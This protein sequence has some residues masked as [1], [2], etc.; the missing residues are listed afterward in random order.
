[1]DSQPNQDYSMEFLGLSIRQI[2]SSTDWAKTRSSQ[3]PTHENMNL[4]VSNQT[5]IY[6]LQQWSQPFQASKPDPDLPSEPPPRFGGVFMPTVFLSRDRELDETLE[7]Q[8]RLTLILVGVGLGI[9]VLTTAAVY[10]GYRLLQT[11]RPAFCLRLRRS[12]PIANTAETAEA[13]RTEYESQITEVDN[14]S[15]DMSMAQS[16]PSL[17]RRLTEPERTPPSRIPSLFASIRKHP[18]ASH[19]PTGV[20]TGPNG[21]SPFLPRPPPPVR[22]T[23]PSTQPQIKHH[24]HHRATTAPQG[25][26]TPHIA[27]WM[28]VADSVV[29][30]HPDAQPLC[31]RVATQAE[32]DL[33][34]GHVHVPW[35][36]FRGTGGTSATSCQPPVPVK[37]MRPVVSAPASALAPAIGQGHGYGLPQPQPPAM[38]LS[39]SMPMSMMPKPGVLKDVGNLTVRARDVSSSVTVNTMKAPKASPKRK[40]VRR[41]QAHGKENMPAVPSPL[42]QSSSRHRN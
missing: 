27:E 38:N 35:A 1:M 33:I 4:S 11:L 9:L 19:R 3:N 12:G 36:S 16:K 6:I 8:A 14:W 29:G 7:A 23:S 30:R 24:H 17:P 13:E 18:S 26:V 25:V 10:F 37:V 42:A 40:A 2:F 21:R 15:F 39:M 34:S 41:A 20:Y 22:L 28:K 31:T 5:C 32:V